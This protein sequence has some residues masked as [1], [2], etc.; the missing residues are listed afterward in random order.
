MSGFQS[1][2]IT[3]TLECIV[4][5]GLNIYFLFIVVYKC[6]SKYF[7]NI[8]IFYLLLFYFVIFF[9]KSIFSIYEL[10][11]YYLIHFL[12]VELWCFGISTL[13]VFIYAFD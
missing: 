4:F 11:I 13:S 1:S 2:L 6:L 12:N 7:S 9:N 3:Y 5:V 10:N 8:S